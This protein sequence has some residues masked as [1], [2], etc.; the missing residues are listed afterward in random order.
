M[1][2]LSQGNGCAWRRIGGNLGYMKAV[3]RSSTWLSPTWPLARQSS[4]LAWVGRPGIGLWSLRLSFCQAQ[5]SRMLWQHQLMA[6]FLFCFYV[7]VGTLV[8]PFC[9]NYG[10]LNVNW[11]LLLNIIGQ[12][13]TPQS[14]PQTW[15]GTCG[16]DP[17][18]GV[19]HIP[20]W[21]SMPRRPKE[22]GVL[23]SSTQNGKMRKIA[24]ASLGTSGRLRGPPS[25]TLSPTSIPLGTTH[26]RWIDKNWPWF[27]LMF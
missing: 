24:K 27:A 12:L 25:R 15:Q 3:H 22:H 26:D 23:Y 7:S 9:S 21:A 11:S 19:P 6:T 2:S 5:I 4:E 8:G 18:R 17:L 1:L 16:G 20:A 14:V 13:S 10:S